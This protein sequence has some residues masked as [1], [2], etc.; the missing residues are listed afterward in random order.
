GIV[1]LDAMLDG[2]RAAPNLLLR[3]RARA[4]R[5]A[6]VYPGAVELVASFGR[7]REGVGLDAVEPVLVRLRSEELGALE[8]VDASLQVWLRAHGPMARRLVL[9][10]ALPVELG[11]K[12]W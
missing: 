2:T 7:G 4:L 3:A 11:A 12:P 5:V 6:S 1:W 8:R 9:A 10:A